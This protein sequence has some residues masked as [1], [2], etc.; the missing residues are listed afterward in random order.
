MNTD[1][2]SRI[3]F[4][5]GFHDACHDRLMDYP[6]RANLPKERKAG[7]LG[8]MNPL[9][10]GSEHAFYRLGYL[11]GQNADMSNGRPESSEGAWEQY[12]K[13]VAK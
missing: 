3:R 8:N 7:Q 11:A 13:D 5:W 9:P 10:K 2:S 12:G 1:F 4:N 6:N